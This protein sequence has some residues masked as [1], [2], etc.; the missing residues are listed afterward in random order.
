LSEKNRELT[1]LSK[2]KTEF[3]LQMAMI[4]RFF[5]FAFLSAIYQRFSL[6]FAEVEIETETFSV[7]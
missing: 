2:K 4:E 7:D 1:K 5:S 3:Q 6:R